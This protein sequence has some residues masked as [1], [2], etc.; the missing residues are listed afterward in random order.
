MSKKHKKEQPLKKSLRPLKDALSRS[1]PFNQ[2]SSSLKEFSAENPPFSPREWEESLSLLQSS[3][4]AEH[5]QQ[6]FS[7]PEI[8]QSALLKIFEEAKD[9]SLLNRLEKTA[10]SKADRKKIKKSLYLLK[11][12][13]VWK[14]EEK[15]GFQMKLSAEP[16]PSYVT[17]IDGVG[18]R[19]AW[20][21]F[22]NPMGQLRLFQSVLNDTQGI[23]EFLTFETS[24][25]NYRSFI[26]SLVEQSEAQPFKAEPGFIFHLLEEGYQRN[27]QSGTPVPEGYQQSRGL[28]SERFLSES[29]DAVAVFLEERMGKFDSIHL[30]SSDSLHELGEFKNWSLD[31]E[32]LQRCEQLLMETEHSTIVLTPVQKEERRAEALKKIVEDFFTPEQRSLYQRRLQDTAFLLWQAD[33]Q[34]DSDCA[35]AVADT[36]AREDFSPTRIP[37]AMKLLEKN[38]R[39]AD[40]PSTPPEKEPSPIIVTP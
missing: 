28:L 29:K 32:S 24:R 5:T 18:S 31:Q 4:E 22:V 21:A 39:P 10:P 16:P 9:T 13:G 30:E 35:L 7:L 12:Q 25:K 20:L 15:S 26:Q 40:K 17:N 23:I 8:L 34:K 33:R 2:L 38:F 6:F 19:A 11:S 14:E 3:T 37:F 1:V 36:L 27:L